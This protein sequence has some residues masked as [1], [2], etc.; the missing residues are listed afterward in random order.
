MAGLDQGRDPKQAQGLLLLENSRQQIQ[1]EFIKRNGLTEMAASYTDKNL[2]VYKDRPV[3]FGPSGVRV[4]SSDG[5]SYVK[6]DDAGFW[7]VEVVDLGV[8]GNLLA[9]VVEVFEGG[10]N[11]RIFCVYYRKKDQVSGTTT[12]HLATYDRASGRQ[13]ATSALTGACHIF[14]LGTGTPQ[15]IV[16]VTKGSTQM[17]WGT[18]DGDGTINAASAV[19][20]NTETDDDFFDVAVLS[21]AADNFAIVHTKDAGSDCELICVTDAFGTPTTNTA[22]VTTSESCHAVA[23]WQQETNDVA[24]AYATTV[25]QD[26]DVATYDESASQINSPGQV[27]AWTANDDYC[28][29]ICGIEQTSTTGIVYMTLGLISSS[30]D[31]KTVRVIKNTY[32]LSAGVTVPGSETDPFEEGCRLVSQPFEDTDGD[33]YIALQREGSFT[34]GLNKTLLI[35]HQNDQIVARCL[36]D[37]AV[38]NLTSEGGFLGLVSSHSDDEFTLGAAKQTGY[39]TSSPVAVRLQKKTTGIL[40]VEAHGLLV[41]AGAHP[42]VFDGTNVVELGFV[43]PPVIDSLLPKDL[44]DL[45]NDLKTQYEAHRVLTGSHNGNSDGT[46]TITE[47]DATTVATAIDLAN[48]L[49]TQYEAHRVLNPHHTNDDTSNTVSA[50]DATDYDTCVTLATELRVDYEAHRQLT[51]G[52]VH[53]NADNTNTVTENFDGSNT[54][55]AHGFQA[56]YERYLQTGHRDQSAP[57]PNVSFDGNAN[58][59]LQAL[60]RELHHTVAAA[61]IVLYKTSAAGSVWRRHAMQ[62]ND[63]DAYQA[64]F[65]DGAADPDPTAVQEP[66]IYTT[67]NRLENLPPPPFRVAWVHQERLFAV[68]REAESDTLR[69]SMEF[70]EGKGIAFNDVLELKV[71]PAGGRI[72]AGATLLGRGVIFKEGSIY[73]FYGKGLNLLGSGAGYSRPDLVDPAK[74]CTDQKLVVE[75]PLGIMFAAKDNIYLLDKTFKV[76]PIG[77][78]VKYHF[79]NITLVS[80]AHIKDRHSVIFASDGVALV[81]DYLYGTWSAFTGHAASDMVAA[82]DT[83][84]LHDGTTTAMFEDRSI[85]QDGPTGS[86][87]AVVHRVRSA[88]IA[89][90]EYALIHRLNVL[91]QN[92][93]DHT[94]NVR[95]AYDYEL[96]SNGFPR[97]QTLLTFDANA[98]GYHT[99]DDHYAATGSAGSAEQ[100]YLLSIRPHRARFKA[101]MIEIYDSTRSGGST[102][103]RGFSVT[104]LEIE[105]SPKRG[106]FQPGSARQVTT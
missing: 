51:A 24:V 40:A 16:Y 78:P 93:S 9:E 31:D 66:Y 97:W 53:D 75:T 28:S 32:T 26:V 73:T 56:V 45:L 85:Y 89:V 63:Q 91:G 55:G 5:A 102:V 34:S 62:A 6:A 37:K 72:T 90:G 65:N 104:A 49:K 70:E 11:D 12:H 21:H 64:T 3:L 61:T 7:D 35:V 77:N 106:L 95:I 18:I 88:W 1:G 30:E 82:A 80:A 39:E 42:W 15:T 14:A 60:V 41:L 94:L 76:Q 67:G 50:A 4:L 83:I 23:C 33:H 19:G 47:D 25:T 46:N 86:K 74:G 10:S 54:A 36:M 87:T 59:T 8:G 2:A 22:A 13:I 68:H 20:S 101:F 17:E 29:E 100:A 27:W 58:D 105:A 92:L 79:D 81:Y 96:D 84:Y 43:H 38:L 98:L 71:S 57:S 103:T 52:P 69:Y 44:F 48:D 99:S